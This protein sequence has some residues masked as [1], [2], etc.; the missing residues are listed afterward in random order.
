M[1]NCLGRVLPSG[2]RPFAGSDDYQQHSRIQIA[3]KPLTNHRTLCHSIDELF[4]LLHLR[5]GMTFSFHHHLRNG[6]GVTNLM[7]RALLSHN[8]YDITLAPSSIFPSYEGI[9][10]LIRA[11]HVRDIHANYI[12]GSVADAIDDGKLSGLVKM[13]THGGRARMIESG[14]LSIDVAFLATP[15]VDL[16]G[17]GSGS[18]GKNACGTLGYAQSD[19]RYAKTVV[20]VT[21]TLVDTLEQIDFPSQYVDYV[22]LVDSIGEAGG[23]VSGT[24]RLTRDPVGLK[25]AS[26]TVKLLDELHMIKN[27]LTM[28]TG[29][30]GIS[31]AVT[32]FVKTVMIERGIKGKFGSGGIT[33]QYVGMLESGLLESLY[34][35]Q[36]FDLDAAISYRKNRQHHAMSAS[37]YGNPFEPNVVVD[38][39]DFVILGATEIDLQFNVNVTTDS[40]G[41]II[42]G[43]GGHADTA[44]GAKV[45]IV[46]TQLIKSRLPIIQEAVTTITTPGEDIDILVTERG[47]AINPKR[48]DLLLALQH[49]GLEIH[50]I[51]E[52]YALQ[53]RLTGI[54]KPIQQ[55]QK[56][57]GVVLYRDGT[58][59]DS[60]RQT[61][62]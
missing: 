7:T 8:L 27:G 53:H 50:T 24:T 43:S 60:I 9:T 34:D 22:L 32:E 39:L 38:Q 26:Q 55:S 14:E 10:E 13:N 25:I 23:I 15:A 44:H 37:Q 18:V 59:I 33:Q 48:T 28:Q 58:V 5:D 29:A 47:I 52:L 57:I 61:I 2:F 42:G 35:V 19:L 12:N 49:S 46:T 3:E 20:L 45:T 21:D 6:D 17:N 56:T 41:K 30:G 11:G 54:P 62:R 31:L 36:C 4:G 16:L 1:T 51:Q 40:F